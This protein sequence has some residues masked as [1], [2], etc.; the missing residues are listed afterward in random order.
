MPERY[1]L[2][3]NDLSHSYGEGEVLRSVSL[4]V[5]PGE[6]VAVLGASGSGKSTLLRAVAGF[7]TPV[8]GR[9]SIDG[10]VVCSGGE[11]RL[12][13]EK[14]GVGMVFQDYA[15]FPHM[16]VYDNVAFGI[17]GEASAKRTVEDLLSLVGLAGLGDRSPATLSGGQQQR[18][19]LARSLAPQP[20]LLVLDEPFANLDGSL[21]FEISREI[22]RILAERDVSALLVTHERTEA[23]GLASRVLILDQEEG[24]VGAT[25]VQI[26]S[27]EEVYS[28]PKTRGV[29][30]MTGPFNVVMGE[31]GGDRAQ[32]G[33]GPVTLVVPA[34]GQ[35]PVILRPEALAV[36]MGGPHRVLRQR[37]TGVGYHLDVETPEGCLLIQ[38]NGSAP[39]VG[40][41]VTVRVVG[42]GA[43]I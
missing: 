37:Y 19:A 6:L 8:S 41:E 18:V 24:K 20:S 43:P 21:R 15:L 29:A 22:Q 40:A 12:S 11:E 13:A 33:L 39:G 23:L 31:A 2:E 28:Q 30:G 42:V 26:G 36:E 9:I 16:S 34:S 1:P 4:E 38:H 3:I 5:R 25:A 10:K 17:Q 35:C 7:V 27:P 14:R 32:T